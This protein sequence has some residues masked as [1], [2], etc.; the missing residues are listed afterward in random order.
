MVAAWPRIDI[1]GEAS[2]GE[3]AV[4]LISEKKPDLVFLDVQMP[5]M[6]GFDV[7]D[8]ISPDA[9]PMVVFVTAF[10]QYALKAFTVSA[11]DYLLKPFDEDRLGA[12]VVRAMKQIDQREGALGSA[13]RKLLAEVRQ[14]V[15]SQVVIKVDGR[16]LFL[17]PDE[18]DMVEASGK[19]VRVHCGTAVHQVRESMNSIEERL[20]PQRFIRVHR[21]SI[22]N[23]SRIREMQPWFQGE[24]VLIL[25]NGKKVVTG[26][27]YRDSVLKLTRAVKG[28][29]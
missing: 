24:Y 28:D 5:R 7:V 26:R 16:H 3:A 25:K 9:M 11:C 1:V 22:V 29:R 10:D 12:A 4:A 8:T 15:E 17:N 2:D 27:S 6:D 19:E 20:D 13:L 23:K 14:P 21:S 18:I